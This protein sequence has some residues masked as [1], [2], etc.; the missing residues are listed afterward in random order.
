MK[1]LTLG[2]SPCPNDTYIFHALVNG[3]IDTGDLRFEVVMADVEE[4]N[5]LAEAG[6]LDVTKLSIGAYPGVSDRYVILDAGAALGK[7][8]GPILVKKPDTDINTLKIGP[9]AIPGKRTTANL[10]MSIFYPEIT[11]KKELIFSDIEKSVSN[12]SASAGLLIHEGRFT[13]QSH[14]LELVSDLGQLWEQSTGSALP[15][16]VIAARRELDPGMAS[17]VSDAI[18][19]S[20]LYARA[21]PE[22][23]KKYIRSHAQEMDEQVTQSHIELYVNDYSVDLGEEGRR[24]IQVI[25]DKGHQVKLLIEIKSPIFIKS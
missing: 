23:S 9:V 12:G 15:L 3:L 4:L 8:V 16:G 5:R 1:T 20:I 11:N 6:K 17:Q 18:R 10:L 19:E 14:G 13:Y 7:G 22:A 25:I 21:H 2:F 24:A